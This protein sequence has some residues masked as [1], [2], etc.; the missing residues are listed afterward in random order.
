[1]LHIG[2]FARYN[3][4]LPGNNDNGVFYHLSSLSPR[5]VLYLSPRSY[6]INIKQYKTKPP[7]LILV[8]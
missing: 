4:L 6:S 2:R 3:V 8:K 1:M 5:Y 7:N